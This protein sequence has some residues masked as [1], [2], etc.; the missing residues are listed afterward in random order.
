MAPTA[1][2]R[3]VLCERDQLADGDASMT[4]KAA[5]PG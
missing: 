4:I 3:F 2:F 1:L 5:L